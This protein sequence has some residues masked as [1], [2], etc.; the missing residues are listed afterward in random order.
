M[1]GNLLEPTMEV[2]AILNILFGVV[3]AGIG[4]WLKTQ[5]EELDRLRILLNR[6]REEMAKEY[7]TK[8]DSSEVLSQIMNKF[9]RLEEKIDRLMER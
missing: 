5:R 4:W 9:D 2:D 6:T 3:I 7:V 8:S 1:A